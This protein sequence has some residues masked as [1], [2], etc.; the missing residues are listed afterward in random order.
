[1]KK[2]LYL[3]VI[4]AALTACG[5]GSGGGNNGGSDPAPAPTPAPTVQCTLPTIASAT[6][7][8]GVTPNGDTGTWNFTQN[9]TSLSVSNVVTP[10]FGTQSQTHTFTATATS[11]N[12]AFT[13]TASGIQGIVTAFNGDIA[14]SASQYGNRPAFL[15]ANPTTTQASL[16]GTYNAVGLEKET[17]SAARSS[18]RQL[19]INQNGTGG[20]INR[21][22][23][24]V[25]TARHVISLTPI[26]Q[27]FKVAIEPS[28]DF[29]HD[30]YEPIGIAYFKV[31]GSSKVVALA[32]ADTDNSGSTP[33]YIQG[34]MIGST[35]STTFPV[36]GYVD[37]NY[38]DGQAYTD[39]WTG[40]VY[41]TST[42]VQPS[43]QSAITYLNNQPQTGFIG[44]PFD[45]NQP[46]DTLISSAL[47][48]FA[49]TPQADPDVPPVNT[50]N[51]ASITFAVRP[52]Q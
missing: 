11:N 12:C 45:A 25:N 1:M 9:G 4:C 48:F 26:G 7:Y 39:A 13:T 15:I 6:T 36:G 50:A 42:T 27:G 40:G 3:T 17:G 34:M 2:A 41:A 37:N 51:A 33:A 30:V 14:T 32:T 44:I 46:V 10:A 22:E 5:G 31:S 23:N 18:Y 8:Y 52:Q 21:W 20:T 24:G 28:A 47:G 35:D 49:A 29:P 38:N 43:Q 19:V 16:A